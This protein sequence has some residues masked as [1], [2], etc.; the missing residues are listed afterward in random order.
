MYNQHTSVHE[1]GMMAIH[2]LQSLYNLIATKTGIH[3]HTSQQMLPQGVSPATLAQLQHQPVTSPVWQSIIQQLT[4]GETY[5]MR[6]SGQFQLLRTVILPDMIARR[7]ATRTLTL[8]SIGC[9]TGEEAYSL[10]ITL[11]ERLPDHAQW[12]I[13]IIGVDIN[14]TALDHARRAIYRPWSFRNVAADFREQYFITT[15]GGDYQ[16]DHSIARMV[17]F[18]RGNILTGL[19][20]PAIDILFC[21]NLLMY[22]SDEQTASA[23]AQLYRLLKDDGWLLMGQAERLHHASADRYDTD[24]YPTLPIYRKRQPAP[25]PPTPDDPAPPSA[26]QA[27]VDALHGGNLIGAETHLT[28]QLQEDSDHVGAQVLLGY[29]YASRQQARQ[30]E[31]YLARALEHDPLYADAHYIR[32]LIASEQND[33]GSAIV[34]LNTAL[35]ANRDHLLALLTLGDIH[36]NVQRP[37]QAQRLW[38]LAQRL[39]E[40]MAD[41]PYVADFSEMTMAQLREELAR[42]L[43]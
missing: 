36:A 29:I 43:A 3:P 14:Q 35:Y 11:Y 17:S 12:Q 34:H 1:Q 28:A 25:A 42:R 40:R 32:A 8:A 16:L 33:D 20:L 13:N 9:S 30:A 4:I 21:R 7:R 39:A 2:S 5:F 26:Y 31:A 10:A 6:N 23:E 38:E 18:Q 19:A 27:A 37:A 15:A 22:F 24:I 41:M